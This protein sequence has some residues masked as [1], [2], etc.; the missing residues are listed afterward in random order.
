M[1]HH[2]FDKLKSLSR[3]YDKLKLIGQ[4]PAEISQ[5]DVRPRLGYPCWFQLVTN[6]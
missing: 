3:R 1:P 5:I 2:V 4:T 6:F